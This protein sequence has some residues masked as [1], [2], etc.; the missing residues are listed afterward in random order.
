M[1]CKCRNAISSDESFGA[2]A[3]RATR[4]ESNLSVLFWQRV[5]W[6]GIAICLVIRKLYD[7]SYVRYVTNRISAMVRLEIGDLSRSTLM[8]LNLN[9]DNTNPNLNYT[10]CRT[11]KNYFCILFPIESARIELKS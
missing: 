8:H 2:Q 5:S 10:G 9:L 11:P 7:P 4:D 1:R 3:L 6:N